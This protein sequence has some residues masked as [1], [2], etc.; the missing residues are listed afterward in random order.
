VQPPRLGVLPVERLV[1]A[2][3]L[4]DADGPDE[5]AAG[6]LDAEEGPLDL[7]SAA[8]YLASAGPRLIVVDDVDR[9]G[10]E[11]AA[12]LSV[13]AARCAASGT[14]VIATSA[15]PLGLPAE[16]R[17]AALAAGLDAADRA[18]DH[19]AAERIEA[20]RQ[21]LTAELRR[22]AGLASDRTSWANGSTRS[23]WSTLTTPRAG[24]LA[25]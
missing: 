6:L 5:L 7:D 11:A 4:R 19:A 17:L 21:A 2:Q 1:W 20:E 9:G 13:V 15:A 25:A 10:A 8:R 14:A 23:G 3:L 18:G 24:Y 16:L 12:M 22:A